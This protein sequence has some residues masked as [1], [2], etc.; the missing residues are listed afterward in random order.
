MK[1]TGSEYQDC[2]FAD[3]WKRVCKLAWKMW[4]SGKSWAKRSAVIK[5]IGEDAFDIGL[6]IGHK[7]FRLSGAETF[8]ISITFVHMNLQQFLGTFGFLLMLNESQSIDS[9]LSEGLK[10]L[11]RPI[12]MRFCLWFL[13][14]PFEFSRRQSIFDFLTSYYVKQ[15]NVVQLDMMDIGKMFPVLQIPAT[16]VDENIPIL[17][18][19]RRILSKCNKTVEFFLPPIPNYTNEYM[20][21]LIPNFP[22]HIIQP[23]DQSKT[24]KSKECNNYTCWLLGVFGSYLHGVLIVCQKRGIWG[25]GGAP[26]MSNKK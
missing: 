1:R 7:D 23:D 12:F 19:I 20:S 11:E 16:C 5:D 3:V 24:K 26:C 13:N 15:V 2:I 6:L 17:D 21:E 10:I 18:F 4:K 9:L 25:W 14:E 8:N 22:P